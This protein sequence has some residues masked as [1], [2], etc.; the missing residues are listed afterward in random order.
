MLT[1]VPWYS[2]AYSLPMPTLPF[3]CGMHMYMLYM[4]NTFG[5]SGGTS[6]DTAVAAAGRSWPLRRLK[7][8]PGGG[9]LGSGTIK[10]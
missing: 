2:S 7:K 1:T 8:V 4:Y 5:G 10:Y 3:H 6:S 9:P